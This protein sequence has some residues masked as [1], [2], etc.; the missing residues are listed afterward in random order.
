MKRYKVS[1][2][3]MVSC[4]VFQA[5]CGNTGIID[6]KAVEPDSRISEP[7]RKITSRRSLS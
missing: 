6:A 1:S 4:T 2:C 7:N 5:V 3:A